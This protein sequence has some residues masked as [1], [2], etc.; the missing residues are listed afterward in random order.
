MPTPTAPHTPATP[1]S[2]M[3]GIDLRALWLV[4]VRRRWLVI[5]FFVATVLATTIVTLRQTRIFESAVTIIIDVAAPRVLEKDQ[6]QDVM[7]AGSG[8]FWYSREYYETQYKV[9]ASRAVAQRVADKLQLGSNLAF[10]RLAEVKDPAEQER[11]RKARNPVA[12]LAANLRVE[13]VKDSRIVKIRYTDPDP[14]LA[15]MIA[16]AFA[17]AYIAENLGVR[18]ATTQNASEWLEQQLVLLEQRLEDSSRALFDFKRS[19]DIVATS[20]EDRQGMVSQRLTAINDALTKARVRKAELEARNDALKQAEAALAGSKVPGADALG[21]VTAVAG[22]DA[23]GGIQPLKMRYIEASAECADLK[24]K[25]LEDHPKV[26]ACGEKLAIAKAAFED[27]VQSTLKAARL[28]YE[29]VAKTERN[30]LALLNETK[31][32]A[33]GLNQFEREYLELKRNYDNNQRLYDL[34]LK[35]LKD[36]GVSGMLQVSNVRVLDRASP[37]GRPVKPDV[38]KNTLLAILLGLAGGIGLAL[39]AELLDTSITAR[40]QVEE[41]LGLAVLGIV[42]S[43]P[44]S[45][46]G[47]PNDLVAH[48]QPKS[49][50]AECLRA[51]RTNLLF[52]SPEKPLRTLLVTSSGPQEGKTTTATS[53]A[54]TMSASGSRVLLVDADMRRPRLHRVF[55]LETR[56]GLSSLIVGEGD[57]EACVQRTHVPNLFVLPCGAVPPNPAELLHT[58]SFRKLLAG[59]AERFD[60]LII[61]SPPVGVVADAVVV[62]TQVDGCLVVLKAGRT[63]RDAA[64]HAVKQLRDV[65]APLLG[66]VLNDL[67]LEDQRYGQYSYYSRY[68]YYDGDAS[69]KPEDVPDAKVG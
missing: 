39:L 33:F 52:M 2:V 36:T 4:A 63:S 22:G 41:K 57:V 30:L 68:G 10:L 38:R 64:R 23:S 6:V 56:G 58:A 15:A 59:L 46:D 45:K 28:E 69:R 50:A 48:A 31:S 27:E 61:D 60:R 35:R 12:I 13:P 51:L 3:G 67:D 16:N 34:I 44:S 9:I 26:G 54:I 8:G 24:L 66:A 21:A 11:L 55:D 43:I 37:A 47:T 18:S 53:L 65:N 19:H 1:A 42:P 17:D 49:A 20:W 29:E 32:D 14:Q 5:P 7:D 62:S 25:Y 40:E